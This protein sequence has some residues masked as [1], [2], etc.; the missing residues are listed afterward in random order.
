MVDLANYNMIDQS[1]P[2]NL[3]NL[4]YKKCLHH[5]TV[6]LFLF[7]PASKASAS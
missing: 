4:D 6:F 5:P 1:A 7:F 3:D 2:D